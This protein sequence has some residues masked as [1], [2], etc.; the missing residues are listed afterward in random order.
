MHEPNFQV[1]EKCE[2]NEAETIDRKVARPHFWSSVFF[3]NLKVSSHA[4][5]EYLDITIFIKLEAEN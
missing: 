5:S 4:E 1:S 2:Q 3:C